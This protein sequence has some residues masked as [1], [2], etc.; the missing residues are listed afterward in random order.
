[1]IH[2]TWYGIEV[3]TFTFSIYNMR[4]VTLGKIMNVYPINI[5]FDIFRTRPIFCLS[6][7]LIEDHEFLVENLLPWTRDSTNRL[8]FLERPDKYDVFLKPEVGHSTTF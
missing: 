3:V 2:N 5:T 8:I 7:R 1:M 6:E 4:V